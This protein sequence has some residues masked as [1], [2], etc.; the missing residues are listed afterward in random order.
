MLVCK[1]AELMGYD[2][3][4]QVTALLHDIGKPQSRKIN[5]ENNHVQFFGHEE[6][7]AKMAES[8]VADLVKRGMLTKS[9]S[10]EVLKLISLHSYLYKENDHE[11]IYSRFKDDIKLFKHL[12]EFGI[13]DDYGRFSEWMG[14]SDLNIDAILKRI[15]ENSVLET[16]FV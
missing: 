8:L 11:K 12:V 6:I 13:C 2:R 5:P 3:V 14:K 4:V 9:E 7:S 1:I 15:E 16:D 10:I